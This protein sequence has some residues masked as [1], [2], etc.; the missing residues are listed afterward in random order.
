MLKLVRFAA[1]AATILMLPSVASAAYSWSSV[2]PANNSTNVAQPIQCGAVI[3][4][5]VKRSAA[6]Q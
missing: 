5:G 2:V 4:W 6:V 1:L 3:G